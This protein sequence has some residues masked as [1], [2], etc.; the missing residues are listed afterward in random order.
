MDNHPFPHENTGLVL[1]HSTY[2]Y[3]DWPV[4]TV[5][6]IETDRTGPSAGRGFPRDR[7]NGRCIQSTPR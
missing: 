3:N 7:S 4:T 6:A 2:V 1:Y 5:R